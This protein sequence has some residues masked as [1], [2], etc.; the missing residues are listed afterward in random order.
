LLSTRFALEALG[1][2]DFGLFS[3]VGGV[4][5]FIAIFNTIMLSTTNRFIATAI[6][7]GNQQKINQTFNVNLVVHI[8]IAVCT[9]IFAYPIGDW[10]IDKFISYSG[11]LESVKLVYHVTIIGSVISFIGVPFNGLLVAKERFIVFSAIDIISQVIKVIGAYSLL[12]VANRLLFYSFR[13]KMLTYYTFRKTIHFESG[14]L[15]WQKTTQRTIRLFFHSYVTGR[16]LLTAWLFI[17]LTVF[18]V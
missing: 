7:Q 14:E 18:P 5:S 4:I 15:Q 8:V 11:N 12:F 2:D 17:K 1:V 13:Y 3:V 10:Y 16:R 9:L 6:G